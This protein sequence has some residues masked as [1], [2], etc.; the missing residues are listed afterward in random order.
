MIH[1][2]VS[3]FVYKPAEKIQGFAIKRANF[4]NLIE[5]NYGRDLQVVIIKNYLENIRKPVCAHREIEARKFTNRMDFVD[6]T[7]FGVG[8]NFEDNDT[9]KDE[10]DKIDK[11]I[12]R[13]CNRYGNLLSRLETFDEHLN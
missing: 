1:N 4:I 10:V 3:E 8:V 9:Y 2:K 11:N 7:A 5:K 12:T 6:L 13:Y